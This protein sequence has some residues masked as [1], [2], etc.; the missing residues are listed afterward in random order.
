[1][2]EFYVDAKGM[3][4][5]GFNDFCVAIES[6]S[7]DKQALLAGMYIAT[8]GDEAKEKFN[9]TNE[10]LVPW[11]QYEAAGKVDFIRYFNAPLSPL[12]WELGWTL[13]PLKKGLYY[14][15]TTDSV[16]ERILVI[17]LYNEI[18]WT[19]P[20]LLYAMSAMLLLP[21]HLGISKNS[22]NYRTHQQASELFYNR[23]NTAA[24]VVI[25]PA[26]MNMA[27]QLLDDIELKPKGNEIAHKLVNYVT[28]TAGVM[29]TS[30]VATLVS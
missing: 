19:E 4:K 11:L 10:I 23:V 25:T 2:S 26:A 16:G 6:L 29:D 3:V 14:H 17:H 30:T 22:P 13:R 20:S 9:P 15:V 21:S 24:T 8:N 1:M 12:S 27:Y 18:Q 5:S 28:K 7:V